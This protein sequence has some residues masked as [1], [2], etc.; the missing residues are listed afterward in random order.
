M[1]Q[2]AFCALLVS[3]FAYSQT[4]LYVAPSG[5]DTQAGTLTAP[6]ATLEK[7]LDKV[8][9]APHAEVQIYLRQ[10]VYYL[11][12]TIH[13]DPERIGSKRVLIRAYGDERVELNGGRK[14]TGRWQKNGEH[15]WTTTVTG[16]SFGQL[17]INGQKQ[18]LARYPN[19]DST[20][21]IF[22]GTASDALGE[23]RIQRWK[24]PE[25]GYIHALHSHEWGSF[26]YRI[27]G[28]VD[29]K[30]IT[31]GG[32]Q[33]NRPSEMHPKYRFVENII[34]ELDYPGEWFYDRVTHTLS[35]IPQQGTDL[36]T[37]RIEVTGLRSLIELKGTPEAPL[38]GVQIQGLRL[39]NT[40]RTFMEPYEPLL[41]SD[42]MLYR[43]AAV[44]LENTE[45]CQIANCELSDLGGN[46]IL[47]SR[48]NRNTSVKGCHI[49]HIGA[50][51][52]GFV[53]D[54]SAVRSP[55]FR[56]E[57][58]VPYEKMDLQPGPKNDRYPAQ[59]NAEDN[60]IHHIGEIEK[61]AT[62]IEISMASDITVRHNTIYQT[63]RAGINIGDG[64][65]GGHLL[66]FNDVFDTV[67]ETGDHGAFNSWG[68]DRFWHPNRKTMDS[69]VAAHPELIKL[70][71]QKTIVI[72]NNRFRCDH[73]W[74]IDLDDGSSNYLIYN[75][76]LLN[77]GL[78]FREGF[79]RTAEN[80]VI[81]N[82]SFHPHVWFKDNEDVFRKNIV[83]RPY[84]PIRINYWGKEL[85]NNLFPD[86]EALLKAQHN[87]T[88]AHSRFGDPHFLNPKQGDYRVA[89]SSPAL[90]LGFQ[91]F[92]MNGFGVQKPRL[93][94]LARS[95]KLPLLIQS[96]VEKEQ[97]EK[98]WLG[99][100][101]RNIRG[102]G[103]RSAYGLPD[104]L[105]ILVIEIPKGAAASGLQ[106]GDVIRTVNGTTV[107]TVSQLVATQKQL[108]YLPTL[109]IGVIRNQ[110][111][112]NI[113]LDK[114]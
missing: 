11:T 112:I 6:V 82:N 45:N 38:R 108:H 3:S 41:R 55:A 86:Q 5:N 99:I 105:G 88:D 73:G 65:W 22:H 72:R 37:A 54:T 40:E 18:N 12:K 62:A 57:W 74:D 67:L 100:K 80:N 106:K 87:G 52:I 34:E 101:V 94:S 17:V 66:E 85:D 24:N 102:A 90:A 51:A 95:P 16:D 59:C 110:Q 103:D 111:L 9:T 48:H 56:Y 81:L 4:R 77:G 61:Q 30:L 79:Y 91:N 36:T 53:G 109:P 107:A 114:P 1:K 83:T 44:Y 21:R 78:K 64:T 25:G 35:V 68:R 14:I 10:G 50:T 93:R 60:L 42:W 31:E 15:I 84:A 104:E 63:P 8:R 113:T 32:W 7:A 97:L 92:P 71:A 28:K 69:L 23:E 76:V 75:N 33:N 43:G 13:I 2:L 27:K 20:A 29:G 26:H 98:T 19:Y 89:K 49:H 58:F 70:D 39:V 46:A 96:T 47:V